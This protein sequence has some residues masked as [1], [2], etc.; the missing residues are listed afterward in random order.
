MIIAGSA[1]R[2]FPKAARALN[3]E[4]LIQHLKASRHLSRGF[5]PHFL[6]MWSLRRDLAS[7]DRAH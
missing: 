6:G 1:E 4:I 2:I 3:M 7:H 5:A